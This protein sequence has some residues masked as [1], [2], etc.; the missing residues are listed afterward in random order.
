VDFLDKIIMMKF[1]FSVHAKDVMKNRN[2]VEEWVYAI[3]ESPTAT[4]NIA[5]DEVHLYGIIDAY[6]GRCLKVVI[7]PLKNL[8]ITTYFDRNMKKRGCK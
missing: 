2:I 1:R 7:N 4:I 8:I 5:N 6:G 3:I